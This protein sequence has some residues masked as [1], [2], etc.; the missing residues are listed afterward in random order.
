M[1]SAP[2]A[3]TTRAKVSSILAV[4]AMTAAI[5]CRGGEGPN[6]DGLGA[7]GEVRLV[8]DLRIGL[9]EGAEE[10][11]FGTIGAIVQL[12]DGTV[13][14]LDS[15]VPIIRRYDAEGVYMHDIG[16]GGEGPG[17]YTRVQGLVLLP[18]RDVAIWD[19]GNN[20][21]TV[22]APDG[23]YVRS[24]SAGDGGY[25]SGSTLR[26]DRE[27]NLYMYNVDRENAVA[28]Q[29]PPRAYFKVSPSGERLG[30]ITVP[31]DEAD[32]PGFV[33][34]TREGRLSNFATRVLHTFAT[35]GHL[36]VGH[37]ATYSFTVQGDGETLFEVTHPWEPVPL[38]PEEK[39]E[40]EAWVQYFTNN[41]RE[42]G[43]DPPDYTPIPDTKPAFMDLHA[44]VDGT[45]WVRRYAEAHDRNR[46]PRPA[47]DPRPSFD[48]WQLPTL[49]AFDEEGTFLGS[50][51]L[52]NETWVSALHSDWIWT[53]QPNEDEENVAVRYRIE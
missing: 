12:P 52:P 46:P 37:N 35:T 11:L 2:S 14:I 30:K 44:G 15:Q 48:W 10:Y 16:R 7:W 18:D 45:I 1:R 9:S 5:A 47:D 40:W 21:I 31:D 13:V 8:E 41:A 20:R 28:G 49:D 32:T 51:E 34:A 29:F 53:V 42:R 38:K 26:V 6:T 27:G 43:D 50:V 22:F 17:E 19:S 24:F 39:A 33:F 36:V 25:Y 23:T 4:A 3:V